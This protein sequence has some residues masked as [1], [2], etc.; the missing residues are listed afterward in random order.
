MV[1]NQVQEEGVSDGSYCAVKK[2]GVCSKLVKQDL[3]RHVQ[4]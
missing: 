2:K 1:Q 3:R 4:N